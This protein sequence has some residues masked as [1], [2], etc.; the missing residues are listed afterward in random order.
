MP[1]SSRPVNR[2]DTGHDSEDAG[3]EKKHDES[4]KITLSKRSQA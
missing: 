4:Q 2:G 1:L 3:T